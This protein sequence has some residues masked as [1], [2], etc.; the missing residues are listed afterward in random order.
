MAILVYLGYLLSFG[1]VLSIVKENIKTME[2]MKKS[3]LRIY[4][5]LIAVVYVLL[6]ALIIAAFII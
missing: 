6:T 3:E 5:V 1:M 2:E 4:R